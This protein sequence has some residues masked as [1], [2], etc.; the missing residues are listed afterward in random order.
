[1]TGHGKSTTGNTILRRSAFRSSTSVASATTECQLECSEIDGVLV[2]VVDTPELMDTREESQEEILQQIFSAMSLC[3]E[4]FNALVFVI[5]FGD[6]FTKEEIETLNLLKNAFGN[7]FIKD[8]CIVIMTKGDNFYPED[9][10]KVKQDYTFEDWLNDQ[11][12]PPEFKKLL[13]ECEKRVVLFYNKGRHE[14]KRELSLKTFLDLV[15]SREDRYT[16]SHFEK[17]AKQR[18][19]MVAK[20]K[21]PAQ[22][23]FVQ[24]Q[25]SL[26]KQDIQV[27][28]DFIEEMQTTS[29]KMELDEQNQKVQAKINQL[30]KRIQSV[31]DKTN[32]EDKQTGVMQE[33]IGQLTSIKQE[34]EGLE[35]MSDQERKQRLKDLDRTVRKIKETG[36]IAIQ[37][38]FSVIKVV[39]AGAAVAV[40][41]TAA[42]ALTAAATTAVEAVK[43]AATPL[44]IIKNIAFGFRD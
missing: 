24:Q 6:R 41:A 38:V 44:V 19:T 33:F 11:V 31:I 32:E 9:F 4:G 10:K 26:V 18:N 20:M 21:L 35:C 40:V 15:K 3:P 37:K 8:F 43:A 29:N 16:S 27:T 28:Q 7:K 2:R 12:E 17:C 14:R 22:S 30:K 23:Q 34:V 42:I 1:K 5:A 36:S 25:L 13:E 39:A